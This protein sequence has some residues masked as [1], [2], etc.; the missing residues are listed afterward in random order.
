MSKYGKR[1]YA[2]QIPG[3]L[4]KMSSSRGS[5]NAFSNRRRGERKE[6]RKEAFEWGRGSVSGRV[7]G[8]TVHNPITRHPWGKGSV[9][10]ERE[11]IFPSG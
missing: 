3:R 10:P 1:L 2:V 11:G 4:T 9:R 8:A 5:N 6:G 7:N